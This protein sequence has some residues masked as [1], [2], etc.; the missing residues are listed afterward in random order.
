VLCHKLLQSELSKY[1][2]IRKIFKNFVNENSIDVIIKKVKAHS[3]IELNEIA[4]IFAKRRIDQQTSVL[5]R[6]AI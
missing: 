5:R 1:S 2:E 6:R 3:G 4:D